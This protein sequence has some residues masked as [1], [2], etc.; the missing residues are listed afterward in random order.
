M[1]IACVILGIA[2]TFAPPLGAREADKV[3]ILTDDDH[4]LFRQGLTEVV[5]ALDSDVEVIQ[6]NSVGIALARLMSMPDVALILLAVKSPGAEG[7]R[8]VERMRAERPDV[9]IV[10]LFALDSDPDTILAAIDAGAKGVLSNQCTPRVMVQALRLVLVGGVYLP[11][12]VLCLEGSLREAPMQAASAATPISRRIE[13]LG[14]TPRQTEVLGL[15]VQGK[16]NKL[17]SRAL[18]VTEATVK[19][20]IAAIYQ[21]LGISNRTEAVFALTRLGIPLP[22]VSS[23]AVARS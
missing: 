5:T 12:E 8:G 22:F 14:L 10:V 21:A 13:Q 9:P 1:K 11:P 20:H 16:S 23:R 19:A 17:I 3:K 7:L 15:L 2:T 4:L 6:A 18:D